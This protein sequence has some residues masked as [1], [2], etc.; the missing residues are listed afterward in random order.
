[1]VARFVLLGTSN[2]CPMYVVVVGTKA[3]EGAHKLQTSVSGRH[4]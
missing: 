4:L 1:M 2:V 3:A